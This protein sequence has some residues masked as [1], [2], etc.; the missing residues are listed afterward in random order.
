MVCTVYNAV[1]H[2]SKAESYVR[3]GEVPGLVEIYLVNC[4]TVSIMTA[5][6]IIE[7]R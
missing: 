6:G 7:G 1:I 5:S 3:K 4:V 2:K